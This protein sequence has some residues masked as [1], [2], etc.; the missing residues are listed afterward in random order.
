M[1][2]RAARV[3]FGSVRADGAIPPIA[4]LCQRTPTGGLKP[5]CSCTKVH[6]TFSKGTHDRSRNHGRLRRPKS[7]TAAQGQ[8][9]DQMCTGGE[10]S[11]ECAQGRASDRARRPIVVHKGQTKHP[12]CTIQDV[13]QRSEMTGLII[14]TGLVV[15]AELWTNLKRW[16]NRKDWTNC[17]GW[18]NRKDQKVPDY[19]Y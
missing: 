12:L 1:I 8:N 9:R 6:R 15:R 16:P 2:V 17:K 18:T 5:C 10:L 7:T 13:W 4:T 11:S 3:G 19:A 14:L